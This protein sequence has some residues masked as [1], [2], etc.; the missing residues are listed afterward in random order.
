MNLFR[1]GKHD[2]KTEQKNMM[3]SKQK[4]FYEICKKHG[5]RSDHEIFEKHKKKHSL[6]KKQQKELLEQINS[7]N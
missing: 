4:V 6:E 7:K 5:E 2:M 1:L 3:P